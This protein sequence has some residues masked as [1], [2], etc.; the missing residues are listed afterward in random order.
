MFQEK[1]SGLIEYLFRY[2]VCRT[3]SY[4][5]IVFHSNLIM[6]K[7]STRFTVTEII[8]RIISHRYSARNT[9]IYSI[10]TKDNRLDVPR[11]AEIT[12]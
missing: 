10:D 9:Q 6:K 11:K 7:L 12:V 8:P 5:S 4:S 1:E 2:S 3:S